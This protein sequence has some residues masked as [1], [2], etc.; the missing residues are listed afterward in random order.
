M[1]DK[2][3]PG[4]PTFRA[5]AV[6]SCRPASRVSLAVGS[7]ARAEQEVAILQVLQKAG[8]GPL[9]LVVR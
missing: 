9:P 1:L 5:L 4:H 2:S 7:G 8:G 6:L 3:L